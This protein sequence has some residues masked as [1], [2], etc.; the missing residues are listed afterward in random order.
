M[1][2]SERGGTVY[3]HPGRK[4]DAD[5]L[6]VTVLAWAATMLSLIAFVA[7]IPYRFRVSVET[8]GARR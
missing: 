5:V 4:H 8:E 6:I 7:G 2:G 3:E 1:R